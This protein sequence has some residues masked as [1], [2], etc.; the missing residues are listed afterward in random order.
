MTWARDP[1]GELWTPSWPSAGLGP[2]VPLTASSAAVSRSSARMPIA[3]IVG[4]GV[5]TASFAEG[6]VPPQPGV[7]SALEWSR[8]ILFSGSGGFPCVPPRGGFSLKD[9]LLLTARGPKKTRTF[10][11]EIA[12]KGGLWVCICPAS[13]VGKAWSLVTVVVRAFHSLAH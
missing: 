7:P 2:E 5:G 1:G 11:L 3:E 13:A 9:C 8:G 10:G 12:R 6:R 4:G